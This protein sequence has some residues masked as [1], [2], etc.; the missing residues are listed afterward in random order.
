MA[1]KLTDEVQLKLRFSEA[2][3][4]RLAREARRQKRSLNAEII[5]R[6]DQSLLSQEADLVTTTAKALLAGLDPDIARK[7]VE[8]TERE[9]FD[10]G[11]K[12]IEEDQ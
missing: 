10:F 2:L 9:I 5:A 12:T 11:V 6:L 8:I 1:R 3:R 4:R 7:M